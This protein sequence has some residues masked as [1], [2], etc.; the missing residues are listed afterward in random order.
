MSIRDRRGNPLVDGGSDGI[1]FRRMA[2][3][4]SRWDADWQTGGDPIDEMFDRLLGFTAMKGTI[5]RAIF[6]LCLGAALSVLGQTGVILLASSVAAY[7]AATLVQTPAAWRGTAPN[8]N[9]QQL[10]AAARLGL[11]LTVSLTLLAI[12]SVTDRFM[13][14]YL[15]GDAEAGKYVAGLDL[16]R[17]TLMMPA[18]SIAATA[19]PMAV[20]INAAHGPAAT[21]AHLTESVELLFAII[22]PAALG[23][24]VI[25]PHVAGLI[26]GV[27]FRP[28]A[29]QVIPIIAIA[30]VFQ[31]LTQQYLHVSF[32]LSNRNSFYLINTASIIATCSCTRAGRSLRNSRD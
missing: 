26:L 10:Y 30:V 31:V 12:S 9:R 15:V 1:M 8:F 21:R 7:L 22:L 16:V 23:F 32:L 5:A 13:I 27:E 28:V 4:P 17:Q 24:A 19:F 20:R 11:P 14:A 6:I 25:S 29:I 3:S 18:I 2:R